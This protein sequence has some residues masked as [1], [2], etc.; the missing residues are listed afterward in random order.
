MIVEYVRYTIPVEQSEVFESA[1]VKIRP[2]LDA[3]PEC[4]GYELTRC[5]ED[6][7]SYLLRL[8]W[9]SI[10]AHLEGFQKGEQF[11]AIYSVIEPYV[12]NITEMRHYAQT[13]FV[14]LRRAR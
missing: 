8:E 6:P 4:L 7:T 13:E 9:E 2:S 11:R 10:E 5:V 1:Y 12:P 14:H 3:A